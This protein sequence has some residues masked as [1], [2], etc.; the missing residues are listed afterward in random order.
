MFI[1]FHFFS[2]FYSCSYSVYLDWRINVH[3][4]SLPPFLG[5]D[6]KDQCQGCDPGLYCPSPG[7]TRPYGNCSAGFYC[8]KNAT[9]HAPTDGVTGNV[10]PIGH[11]CPVGTGTP[12]PC[13]PGTYANTT[14][15][16]QCST[17]PAGFY[18]TNRVTPEFCPAGFYCPTGTGFSWQPCP[19]GTFS[20]NFGIANV[21]QCVPCLGGFYC[22]RNNLTAPVGP[23]NAGFYCRYHKFAFILNK[24]LKHDMPAWTWYTESTK[25]LMDMLF[26]YF[27]LSVPPI[28]LKK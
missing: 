21:T 1:L 7:L 5:L 16:A 18:C 6:S 27:L 13:A 15:N 9:T 28:L 4:N 17:C 26:F 8:S 10:C 19:Q 12:T 25:I 24:V 22:N 11:Y 3:F 14:Q 20:A 2:Q 23:C